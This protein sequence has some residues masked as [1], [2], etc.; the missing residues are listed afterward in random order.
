MRPPSAMSGEDRGIEPAHPDITVLAAYLD[1]TGGA[2][3][4]R[5]LEAHLASCGDCRLELLEAGRISRAARHPAREVGALVPLAAAAGI[6]V[7]LLARGPGAGEP[8]SPRHREPAVVAAAVPNLVAPLGPVH[9]PDSLRW[10]HLPGADRYEVAL[11][12]GAGRIL[13][14]ASLADTAAAFPATPSLIPG[15]VYFWRVR[16]RVGWDRW[17]ESALEEFRLHDT[18]SPP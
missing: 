11:F 17:A 5:G 9:T 15:Q 1:R 4:L 6:A 12:D 2:A 16:A 14:E 8:A 13:W 10:T 3:E 7:A 18:A